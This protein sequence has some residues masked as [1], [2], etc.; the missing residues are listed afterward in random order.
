MVSGESLGVSVSIGLAHRQSGEK[1]PK[2]LNRADVAL[3]AAKK[4]GRNKVTLYFPN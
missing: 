4:D 1:L 3:Y 2:L